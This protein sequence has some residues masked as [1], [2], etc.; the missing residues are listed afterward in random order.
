MIDYA[1]V[2]TEVEKIPNAEFLVMNALEPLNFPD[3]SFDVVNARFISSFMPRDAWV[4]LLKECLRVLRPGGIFRSTE[5]DTF[6]YANSPASVE[7]MEVITLALWNAGYGF[8]PQGTAE[9]LMPML[10]DFIE[11]AGFVE[12]ESIPYAI[13]FSAGTKYHQLSL[14]NAA[15][16]Y[17]NM[18]PFVVQ[19][20]AISAKKYDQ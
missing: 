8:S 18:K 3:H 1:Q 17:R 20:R 15:S 13:N 9:G 12:I 19:A 16:I 6:E 14:Q 7:M 4:P 11:Q 10:F 5:G 2:C